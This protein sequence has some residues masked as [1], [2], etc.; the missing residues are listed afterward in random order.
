[1]PIIEDPLASVLLG[2]C[3]DLWMLRKTGRY[4]I[5]VVEENGRF[6]G[7]QGL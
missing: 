6:P 7:V 5:V 3:E 2:S 4:V 1:M